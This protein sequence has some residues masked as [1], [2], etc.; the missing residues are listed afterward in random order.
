MKK[1]SRTFRTSH[2]NRSFSFVG[3]V[4]VLLVSLMVFFGISR[5]TAK[6][7]WR[8]TIA[9]MSE[10]DMYLV[11]WD[12]TKTHVVLLIIP[13]TTVI[14]GAHGYGAYA[15]HALHTLDAIDGKQGKVFLDSIS[16]AF[17]IP[18]SG[19]A[20]LPRSKY[21]AGS[22]DFL[23][24]VFSWKSLLT[25]GQARGIGMGNWASYVWA[26]TRL[27]A[28][29]VDTVSAENTLVTQSLPDGSTASIL[30]P[31]RFDFL[32]N[33][34]FIDSGMRQERISVAVYNTTG[35]PTIGTRAARLLG[36]YG[37]SIVSVGN[38]ISTPLS[39]CRLSGS[40]ASVHTLTARFIAQ[41]FDCE[42][43]IVESE[44]EGGAELVVRFGTEYA[45]QFSPKK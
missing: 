17:G 19:F 36:T 3:L 28:D 15:L 18:V 30:D 16:D 27:K 32:F 39:R 31:Q 33:R 10:S 45:D 2:R 38:D 21:P 11:S 6:A 1:P 14:E 35:T 20:N 4:V 7:P 13:T 43:V 42:K 22:L 37:I 12:A 9:L 26:T 40:K 34:L 25:S 23:R 44:T 5:M 41:Y 24:A 8:Q 29:A